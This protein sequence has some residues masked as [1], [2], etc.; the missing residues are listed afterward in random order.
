MIKVTL[1]LIK[2]R[3]NAIGIDAKSNGINIENTIPTDF[4]SA[5][6]LKEAKPN[7]WKAL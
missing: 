7:V 2:S 4:I 3:K 6:Y 5:L 1:L